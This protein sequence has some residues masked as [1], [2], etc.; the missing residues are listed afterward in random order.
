MSVEG[1]GKMMAD[2]TLNTWLLA[3]L[4]AV[5]V[6][7][8]KGGLPGIGNITIAIYAIIFPAKLSVGILLPILI[9]ADIVTVCLY[10]RHALWLY[11]RKLLPWAWGG[12]FSGYLL[13]GV[14]DDGD[15]RGLIGWTL[16]I[17]T[18]AHFV[19]LYLK[20]ETAAFPDEEGSDKAVVWRQRLLAA[21]TG[22][23]GGFAS[24]VANAAGPIAALYLIIA[25]LPKHAFVGTAAWFFLI[26]NLSKA[27][28]MVA[29]EMITPATLIVSVILSAFAIGGV[30]FGRWLIDHIQQKWFERLI[31][32]FIIIAGARLALY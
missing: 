19:R 10:R 29:R 23:G 32:T 18:A 15:V 6:G 7:L 12:I 24:M 30:F 2:W 9:I 22:V 27:P 31:W 21:G 17:M 14:M 4:G 26:V 13:L 3:A 1:F 28:F 25:G 11:I 5:L 16:L 8:G 20:K